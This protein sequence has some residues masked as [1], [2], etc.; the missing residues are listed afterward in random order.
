MLVSLHLE[1]LPLKQRKGE[2][3]RSLVFSNAAA[4]PS[5]ACVEAH[6]G[7]KNLQVSHHVLQQLIPGESFLDCILG[8]C[9]RSFLSCPPHF[10]SLYCIPGRRLCSPHPLSYR[11]AEEGLCNCSVSDVLPRHH[12]INEIA[13]RRPQASPAVLSSLGRGRKTAS[14][15]GRSRPGSHIFC[16][17]VGDNRR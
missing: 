2:A 16:L 12:G 15:Q 7:G 4:R 5:E 14:G 6:A 1:A 11:Q 3:E 10:P 8:G 9:P 17:A 13:L